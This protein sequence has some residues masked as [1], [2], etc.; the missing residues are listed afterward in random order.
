ME[1]VKIGCLY[2]VDN[3]T[4]ID[5]FTEVS[6]YCGAYDPITMKNIEADS[7]DKEDKYL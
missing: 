4:C 1:K 7:E 2:C 5:A 6:Q 3:H